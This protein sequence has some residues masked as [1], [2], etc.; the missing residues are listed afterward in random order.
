MKYEKDLQDYIPRL[1]ESAA[2]F[3]KST[4]FTD[5]KFA[6]NHIISATATFR[7]NIK[8]ALD[9]HHIAFDTL[10][11]E[12]E[13]IFMAIKMIWRKFHP[14]TRHLAT[15]KGKKWLTRSWMIPRGHS[16]TLLRATELKKSSLKLTYSL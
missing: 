10:T 12:L 16:E 14:L 8:G 2:T 3:F 15:L 13:G 11:E 5:I 7:D 1:L 4:N 9:A 6:M